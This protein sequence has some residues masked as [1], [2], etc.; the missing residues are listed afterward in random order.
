MRLLLSSVLLS[1]SFCCINATASTNPLVLLS[2][3]G[4]TRAIALESVNLTPEPFSPTSAYQW[5]LDKQTRV[6]LFALNLALQPG[7]GASTVKADAEDAA[8]RHYELLVEYVAPVPSQEWLT[9][10]ELRLND[11][12]ADTD[13]VLVGLSYDGRNSN[14]V[15]FGI[16]HVGGGPPDD[17]DAIP[18]PA[19]PYVITGQITEG[20]NALA[21][22]LIALSGSQNAQAKSDDSGLYSFIVNT[23]GDYTISLSKQF[24]DFAPQ[25][26]VLNGVSNNRA[27]VNFAGTRQTFTLAG[28]VTDENS[29]GVDGIPVAL[30]DVTNGT[31][32]TVSSSNGGNFSFANV[33]AGF[34]YTVTPASNN[35]FTFTSQ[36]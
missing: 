28:Q 13:D 27:N 30:T 6:I 8:H 31:A 32:T 35:I 36:T 17:P 21:G 9:A 18:T 4:S 26:L 34:N 23:A 25:N 16:G 12:L 19:P 7:D 14:R 29:K 10:I 33:A 20:G 22:V 15:R 24:Y 5:G 3:S 2:Q 1:F 11:D